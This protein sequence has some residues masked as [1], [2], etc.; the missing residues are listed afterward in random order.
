MRL[1][2]GDG[3]GEKRRATPGAQAGFLHRRRPMD[4]VDRLPKRAVELLV[5]HLVPQILEQ[6]AAE[7][8][9]HA[10]VASQLGAGLRPA[11]ATGEG[12]HAQHARVLDQ[13][14]EQPPPAP[15]C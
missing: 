6:G 10:A 7:A 9:N 14:V 4:I 3:A 13:R 15:G 12:D 1:L 11:E 2:T 8:G 5:A